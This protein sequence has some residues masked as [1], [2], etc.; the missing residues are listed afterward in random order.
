MWASRTCSWEPRC[1]WPSSLW[2]CW[3]CSAARRLMKGYALLLAALLAPPLQAAEWTVRPGESIQA[4]IDRAAPGD[5]VR[6]ERGRYVE[7]LSI[8]KALT[9]AGSGRPTVSGGLHG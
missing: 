6:V 9:L 3:R 5:T 7:N 4:A 2:A 1:S 8:A